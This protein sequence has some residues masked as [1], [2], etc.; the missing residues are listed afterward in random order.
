MN[1][2][3]LIAEYHRLYK[4]NTPL[5]TVDL[6]KA[7]IVD[8]GFMPVCVPQEARSVDNDIVLDISPDKVRD[9]AFRDG[10]M[11]IKACFNELVHCLQI[12]YDAVKSI[13][14]GN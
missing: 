13:T 11:S 1:R 9:I 2:T 8:D 3:K 10:Y 14:P 6:S 4:T 5:I 12:P 7:Y